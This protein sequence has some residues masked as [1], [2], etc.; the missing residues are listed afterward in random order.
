MKRTAA[1]LGQMN[2]PLPLI[3]QLLSVQTLYWRIASDKLTIEVWTDANGSF[4][5][6]EGDFSSGVWGL[7]NIRVAYDAKDLSDAKSYVK[8]NY[9]ITVDDETTEANKTMKRLIRR[10]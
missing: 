9:V 6:I 8:A 7:E 4:K 2:I 10:S 1:D 3:Q 5:V